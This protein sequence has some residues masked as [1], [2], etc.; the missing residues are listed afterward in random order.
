M[1]QQLSNAVK[2]NADDTIETI[3]KKAS[4]VKPNKKQLKWNE[5]VYTAFVHFG[6]N[7]FTDREWGDGNEDPKI[8][9]P[10]DFDAYKIVSIF[11]E[12][13]MKMVI[14]TC[15]HHDGFC[16]WPS[17][18]TNHSVK[19][20]SYKNGQGDIV[21]EMAKACHELGIA[22]GI[23]LSPWDRHEKTYGTGKAYNDFYIAQ[24]EELLKNYAPIADV[25]LDGACG[26]GEN[27]KKQEYDWSRIFKTVRTL[28]PE[29]TISGVAPDVRWCGNEAGKCRD[30]EWNVVPIPNCDKYLPEDSPISAQAV[31]NHNIL[32]PYMCTNNDLGSISKL[33]EHAKN[34][35]YLFWYPAQVDVSIRPGWFYHEYE[36]ISVK[37]VE[38]L[39]DIYLNSVGGNT[40]LL[41]NVPPMP[42]G[43]L[44]QTDVSRLKTLACIL[45]NTFD[46]NYA[47]GCIKTISPYKIEVEL[48]HSQVIDLIEIQENIVNGQKIE[49][50][51]IYNDDTNELLASKT[52]VGSR[53][54]IKIEPVEL[55]N[56]RIEVT[57]SRD[58][59]EI[60]KIG[61][62]KMPMLLGE[63]IIEQTN[64]GDVQIHCKHPATIYYSINGSEEK[65]YDQ[66]FNL[67]LGGLISARAEYSNDI[68][69]QGI[70]TSDMLVK[71]VIG[72]NQS[73][74]KV[75]K[76]SG[77]EITSCSAILN[78]DINDYIKVEKNQYEIIVDMNQMYN[79]TGFLY[80]PVENGYDFNYNC[81]A[82]ELSFSQDGICWETLPVIHFDNIGHLPKLMVNYFD[83]IYQ[84][85]Y[86]KFK[87][88]DSLRKEYVVFSQINVIVK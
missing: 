26:E 38:E 35:D 6:I 12:A 68:L 49:E 81:S 76:T 28:A 8:F 50:I 65:I 15:K 18:Y 56:I 62:Y 55:K 34:G 24:L 29:A 37:S 11:K 2:L 78:N 10:Y 86:L 53:R 57:Q 77:N 32:P 45:N 72:V 33:Q 79:V 60:S 13:G 1:M 36:D 61:V 39:L 25:W 51:K 16:L 7:T 43:Q 31:V 59:P 73:H 20:S 83:S 64:L 27:G 84:A 17:K 54:Y 48:V 58:T 4:A 23:Y 3:R 74:W 63:P 42:N 47:D 67:E 14:L 46:V 30:S 70:I 75:V 41:L 5:Y 52:T 9:N 85:R 71:K 80:Q 88:I 87:V 82:C 69:N 66:P 44:H 40:Q 19:S 21:G 22:F